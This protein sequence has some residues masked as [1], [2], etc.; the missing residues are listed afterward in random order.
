MFDL[1]KIIFRLP[2]PMVNLFKNIKH[3]VKSL[4]NILNNKKLM[5]RACSCSELFV[6]HDGSVYPCCRVWDASSMKIGHVDDPNIVDKIKRFSSFCACEKFKMRKAKS[7]ELAQ[8]SMI[9]LELSLKC[10]ATCAMCCVDAPSWTGD[11]TYYES[12]YKLLSRLEPKEIL[13]QGGEILIQKES[14]NWILK[15]K[16]DFPRLKISLV[17][18]GNVESSMVESL[19]DVFYRI[20]I[21]FVGLQSETV[22][23][24]MGLDVARTLSFVE[25]LSKTDVILY[26]K[27]LVTPINAHEADSFY[28][29]ALNLKPAK[30]IFSDSDLNKY[31]KRNTFDNYWKKLLKRSEEALKRKI[32][33]SK[34]SIVSNRIFVGFDAGTKNLFGITDD[35]IEK[36]SLAPYVYNKD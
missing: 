20:T 25:E 12:L 15:L 32:I 28:S 26:L 17:T 22:K 24:I 36:N 31:I 19:K 2:K 29:W 35:Y 10:Q 6:R 1:Y 9:N 3:L 16:K 18:N 33:I 11:F 34:D 8:Y 23:K 30:I 5:S 4:L 14:M 7:K 21:S 13:L 27:Y